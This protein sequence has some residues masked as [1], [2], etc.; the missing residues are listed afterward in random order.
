MAKMQAILK[1]SRPR[2]IRKRRWCDEVPLHH[3]SVHLVGV[4]CMSFGGL[5]R[6][7]CLYSLTRAFLK[8]LRP[9]LGSLQLPI[10]LHVF[11]SKNELFP[12]C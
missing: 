12:E 9:K 1:I 2:N 3:V 11:N 10:N 5:G 4:D 7:S 8:G 6:S